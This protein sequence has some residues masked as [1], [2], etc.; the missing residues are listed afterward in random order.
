MKINVYYVLRLGNL[1]EIDINEIKKDEVYLYIGQYSDSLHDTFYVYGRKANGG[2]QI[3]TIEQKM[4]GKGDYTKDYLL[5]K[6]HNY[7]KM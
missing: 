1:V 2:N 7:E 3:Y 5:K 4:I 6:L